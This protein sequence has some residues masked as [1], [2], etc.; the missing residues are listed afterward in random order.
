LIE[1]VGS[2]ALSG[3][4]GTTF[5][6][7]PGFKFRALKKRDFV[8]EIGSSL[9]VTHRKEFQNRVVVSAFYHF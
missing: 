8:I 6:V 7:T 5:N 1:F 2:S 9:P 4:E 3:G